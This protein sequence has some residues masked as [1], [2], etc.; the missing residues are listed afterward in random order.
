MHPGEFGD[1]QNFHSYVGQSH[2]E[3]AIYDKSDDSR[4][5]N[6][7]D[8]KTFDSTIGAKDAIA[9]CTKLAIFC[10]KQ[11]PWDKGVKDHLDEVFKLSKNPKA[12]NSDCKIQLWP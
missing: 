4:K 8:L 7:S 3:H 5:L 2:D 1:I 11:V 6:P 9:A 10:N 12:S